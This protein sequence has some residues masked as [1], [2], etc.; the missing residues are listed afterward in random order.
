MKEAHDDEELHYERAKTENERGSN[1]MKHFTAS[2]DKPG[3]GDN[4]KIYN[5]D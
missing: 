5:V 3:E 2:E 4:A 1:R